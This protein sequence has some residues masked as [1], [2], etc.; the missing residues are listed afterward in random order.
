MVN[1]ENQNGQLLYAA[2]EV[3]SVEIYQALFDHGFDV[4]QTTEVLGDPLVNAA[5]KGH[6]PLV[7]H[8]IVRGADPA[9]GHHI[10]E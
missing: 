1:P 10:S 4:H 5:D 3:G 6:E 2:L 9:S 7:K 8:L